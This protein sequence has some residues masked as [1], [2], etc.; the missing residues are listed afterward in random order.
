[1][2]LDLELDPDRRLAL[3]YVPAPARPALDALW[4]LDVT[5]AAVLAGGRDKMVSRIRLAWWREALGKL[6][7]EA[8]PPEP[9]LRALAADVLPAG[10]SGAELAAMEEGWATLLSD[11]LL[12]AGE[13]DFYARKRGARL[14]SLSA[15]LLGDPDFPVEQAGTLWALIDLARHSAKP[16]E[17]EAALGIAPRQ[18]VMK[19]PR[20]LRPLGML[21]ALARRDLERSG[22]SWERQ[23]SPARMVRMIRHRL[24]G[25]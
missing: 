1:M 21:A 25:I 9:V 13:L 14:F 11:S 22:A 24:T 6:D 4:R 16:D 7:R 20:R 12:S 17:R 2:T 23:G 15:R 18:A 8:A 19:W 3:A 10:I 5:F